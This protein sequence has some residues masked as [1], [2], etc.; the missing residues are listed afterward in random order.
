MWK[1]FCSDAKMV[2]CLCV[3]TSAMWSASKRSRCWRRLTTRRWS[4]RSRSSMEI[5]LPS[6]LTS[7]PSTLLAAARWALPSLGG[8]GVCGVG[9]YRVRTGVWCCQVNTVFSWGGGL[10]C[11]Y[12][13]RL[14]PGEHCLLLGWGVKV[15]VQVS[16]AARWTL[17]SLGVGG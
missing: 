17:P 16:A 5:T 12:R 1:L 15:F 4:G 13:C 8:V 7:F 14:L 11:S 3:K 2:V 9:G 6:T 10:K